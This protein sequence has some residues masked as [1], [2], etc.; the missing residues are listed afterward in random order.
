[1]LTKSKKL[2]KWQKIR[3]KSFQILLSLSV[4]LILSALIFS[5][6]KIN[7]KR[8]EFQTKIKSLEEEIQRLEKEKEKYKNE[9]SEVGGEEYL[10]KV[11]KEDFSY[12]EKEEKVVAFVLPE[13]KIETSIKENSEIKS[14]FFEVI[15]QNI[16]GLVEWFNVTFPR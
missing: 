2:R 13:E 12:K 5:N 14:S 7:K 15:K 6:W 8:A 11:L 4:L 9:I 3:D 1:M 16:A 10:K